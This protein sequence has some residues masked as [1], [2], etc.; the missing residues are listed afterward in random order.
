MGPV[1][2]AQEGTMTATTVHTATTAST[3]TSAA[4]STRS[5]PAP[6]WRSGLAA[7]AVA[8]VATTA[9]A[10][11]GNAAGISLDIQGEPIPLLGFA[12]LTAIFSLFGVALAA[13]LARRSRRA[14]A[15]F[16]RTTVALTA[17]SLVPDVLVP[18]DVSTKALLMTT[19]LVAAAIVVPAIARRLSR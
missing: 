15:M 8:S 16:V 3:D 1:A 10:A 7:T 12:Q 13:V 11:L 4:S 17:L 6:V 9:V 18:A 5:R 19:H 2:G 14:R